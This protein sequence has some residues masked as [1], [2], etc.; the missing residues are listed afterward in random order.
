[1]LASIRRRNGD[2]PRNSVKQLRSLVDAVGRLKFWDDADLDR[3]MA[4][5]RGLLAT[6]PRRRAPGAVERLVERLGA[7]SRVALLELERTPRRSGREAGLPD[8]LSALRALAR[9]ARSTPG[10]LFD[11]VALGEPEVARGGRGP[12][13][14]P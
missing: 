5:I 14:A 9:R 8:D 13:R 4:A 10:D 12:R 1:V 2:L 3:E 11:A 6:E 7:E